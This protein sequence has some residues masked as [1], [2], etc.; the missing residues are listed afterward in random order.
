MKAFR[1]VTLLS[2]SVAALALAASP[3]AYAGSVS[4]TSIETNASDNLSGEL[5]NPAIYQFNNTTGTYAGDTLNSVVISFVG[6][7]VTTLTATNSDANNASTGVGVTSTTTVILDST[8][9]SIDSLLIA[10]AFKDTMT[11]SVSGQTVAATK[12]VTW[13]P[14]A[15]TSAGGKTATIT[16]G[17]SL[18]EGISSL[19]FDLNSTTFVSSG[20]TG[21][22]FSAGQVGNGSGGTVEVTYNYSTPGPV[23]TV[24]E[25]GTLTL[26]GTGLLGLA[27]MLR[28]KFLA[29]R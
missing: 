13:G 22:S 18:F 25:P 8:V 24:P 5:V 12:T 11:S 1:N 19:G 3:L 29:S 26:F 14:N 17:L 2:L 16:S 23:P 28:S 21:G 4:F 7:G 10:N 15:M 20:A 6:S 27:G 9:G